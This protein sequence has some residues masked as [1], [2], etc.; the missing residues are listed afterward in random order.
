MTPE[1]QAVVD[2]LRLLTTTAFTITSIRF[3]RRVMMMMF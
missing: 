3:W 1:E 2:Q